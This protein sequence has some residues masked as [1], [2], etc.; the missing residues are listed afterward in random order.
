MSVYVYCTKEDYK[1][2]SYIK[3][4]SFE[5]EWFKLEKDD[6]VMVFQCFYNNSK[7]EIGVA[8]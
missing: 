3:N 4:R 1:H 2:R 5:N 8:V 6:L 7:T